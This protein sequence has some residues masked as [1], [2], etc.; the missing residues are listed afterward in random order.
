MAQRLRAVNHD[1]QM[2]GGCCHRLRGG[3]V[4]PTQ[5]VAQVLGER[6]CCGLDALPELVM[7]LSAS[8]Y[9]FAA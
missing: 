6:Y 1:N 9:Y 7:N 3:I 8:D 5:V 2:V 4:L